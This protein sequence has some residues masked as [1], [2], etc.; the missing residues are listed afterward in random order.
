MR[1]KGAFVPS[2]KASVIAGIEGAK[3]GGAEGEDEVASIHLA[4]APSSSSHVY[5]KYTCAHTHSHG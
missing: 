1:L 5:I 2:L 3:Q 4:P